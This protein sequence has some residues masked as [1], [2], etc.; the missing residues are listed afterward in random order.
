MSWE[1]NLIGME[2]QASALVSKGNPPE[3]NEDLTTHIISS[4]SIQPMEKGSD[5]HEADVIA[6]A[7]EI[8]CK[9]FSLSQGTKRSIIS[10]EELAS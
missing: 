3:L 8:T 5:Y 2:R 6:H 1:P 9:L 7:K 4:L 10:Q